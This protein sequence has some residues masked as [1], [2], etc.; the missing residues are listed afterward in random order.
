MVGMH[1]MA[2]IEQVTTYGN[3]QASNARRKLME[4]RSKIINDTLR[5]VQARRR[6][7]RLEK[8]CTVAT[9]TS[10]LLK[11]NDASGNAIMARDFTTALA[12]SHSSRLS[13]ADSNLSKLVVLDS[14]R[15][16]AQAIVPLSSSTVDDAL[17]S[18]IRECVVFDEARYSE[19]IL[20]YTVIDDIIYDKG[21]AV[22]SPR[23]A[24]LSKQIESHAILRLEEAA[25]SANIQGSSIGKTVV[26]LSK[27]FITIINLIRDAAVWHCKSPN[28]ET[29]SNVAEVAAWQATSGQVQRAGRSLCQVVDH[30]WSRSR[31]VIIEIIAVDVV[32]VPDYGEVVDVRRRP[33]LA[34]V[35]LS[36]DAIETVRQIAAVDN[37]MDSNS[38]VCDLIYLPYFKSVRADILDR[39]KQMLAC[40]PW[41][42]VDV[43]SRDC[44]EPV[45]A[46]DCAAIM[47]DI[48][49]IVTNAP[50]F[51]QVLSLL[52]QDSLFPWEARVAQLHRANIRSISQFNQ[53]AT[54]AAFNGVQR[55]AVK[56]VQVVMLLEGVNFV[57]V[58]TLFEIFETYLAAV[59]ATHLSYEHAV[60]LTCER[61]SVQLA[62]LIDPAQC[63]LGKANNID[64][65]YGAIVA[66]D[67]LF[68]VQETLLSS[69]KAI[70]SYDSK[71]H[72]N[73]PTW[74]KL[75]IATSVG[76]ELRTAIYRAVGSRLVDSPA[77]LQAIS[78]LGVSV[79]LSSAIQEE[80]NSYVY[81]VV[82]RLEGLWASLTRA[83]DGDKPPFCGPSK[84]LIWTHAV[85]AAFEAFVEG[86]ARVGRCSTEGRA[87]MSMDLQ[88]LQFS[89]DKMHP[90]RPL[91]GAAYADS[92]IKAWYFDNRDLRAWVAQNDENYTKRQL[93]ALV[94]AHEFKTLAVEIRR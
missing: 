8:I 57:A 78:S 29:P 88:V 7:F 44:N 60:E 22:P 67:S 50:I 91:R 83:N 5:L 38:D 58:E 86:F 28:G 90:A 10:D 93:A 52:N 48:Q 27:S 87:L 72:Q 56:F 43:F 12:L 36:L 73:Y 46:L 94:F 35:R 11:M 71:I 85:Q 74:D 9:S 84:G 65:V 24:R 39:L 33:S 13:L 80:C 68:I 37:D 75:K 41:I 70:L 63:Q 4:A 26:D 34:D 3:V 2:S 16:R 92:Y 21:L 30:I 77:I 49:T 15:E 14:A 69:T 19:I 18:L 53:V 76:S 59:A 81:A 62:R 82:A 32:P 42:P 54:Q 89:L 1:H 25:S 79:W 64:D 23:L 47:N 31:R 20:A 61:S 51:D 55:S 66:A 40:E 17:A 6:R 45:R